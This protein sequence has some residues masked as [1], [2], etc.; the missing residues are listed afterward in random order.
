MSPLIPNS[1]STSL[2]TRLRGVHLDT[3][4][5]GPEVGGLVEVPV[6]TLGV[7]LTSVVLSFRRRGPPRWP[8]GRI[9]PE[10]TRRPRRGL[11]GL[12]HRRSLVVRNG[13]VAVGELLSGVGFEHEFV[14]VV[15]DEP[16]DFVGCGGEREERVAGD[17][18]GLIPE[19]VAFAVLLVEVDREGGLQVGEGDLPVRRSSPCG[20]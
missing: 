18:R 11:R 15:G 13:E 7:G 4:L 3:G 19:V 2:A 12:R 17:R 20:R 14:G 6:A 1:L 8:S 16:G 10:C 9:R 5:G